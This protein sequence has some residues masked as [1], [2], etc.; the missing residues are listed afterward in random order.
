[1]SVW[2]KRLLILNHW[3]QNISDMRYLLYCC[4]LLLLFS[5]TEEEE[6]SKDI[7][8]TKDNSIDLGKEIAI[9]EEIDIKLFL[10][11]HRDWNMIKTGS[12]L[13]YNIYEEGTIDTAYSPRPG[14]IARIEYIITLLDGSE[15]YKTED[16]EYEEIVVDNSGI[17]TGIQEGIKKMTIGDRARLIIPSHLGHGLV[18]DMNKIPP[19]TPL[20]IDIYL[21]GIKI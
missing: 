16:D 14:D 17:E 10:E 4:S 3:F 6:K 20:V 1:M 13:Q 9:K 19:L 8:W 18:G 15:C 12:G 2:M 11:S 21:T 7:N 5:C